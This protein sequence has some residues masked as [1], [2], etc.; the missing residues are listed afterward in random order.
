MGL[1]PD[2]IIVS[3]LWSTTTTQP[4]ALQIIGQCSVT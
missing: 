1:T 4:L 3:V 2:W